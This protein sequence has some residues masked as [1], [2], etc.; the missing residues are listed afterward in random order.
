VA[1]L[2]CAIGCGESG[3]GTPGDSG[4]CGP[5]GGPGPSDGGCTGASCPTD[6]GPGTDGG[7]AAAPLTATPD[8]V[9]IGTTTGSSKSGQVTLQNTSAATVS[10]QSLPL[11]GD[12]A[13]AFQVSGGGTLPADLAPGASTTL[14]V[15]FNGTAGVSKAMLSA[16]TPAG[17][18][19]VPLGGMGLA[20]GTEP[21]L[22]WIF[23]VHNIPV[24]A[25]N[26]D[27]SKRDFPPVPIAG[28]ETGIQSF[29]KA[30][31]GPVTLQ[32][33][34]SF[35]PTFEPVSINGWYTSGNASARNNLFTI[36]QAEA[37]ALDP[38]PES[39]T[40]SFD[41]GTTAFGFWN[42]WPFWEQQGKYVIYQ[43]DTLNTWDTGNGGVQHHMRVYPYRNPDGTQDPH[44]YILTTEEAPISAGPDY[45]DIV[46]V[47]RN[48]VPASGGGGALLIQNQDG[49]PANDRMI[50]SIITTIASCWG[51]LTVK[52]TGALTVRNLS[53]SN[54]NVTAVDVTDDFTVTPST[55]LPA[56]LAPG[57]SLDL[58]VKFVATT[59]RVH[60]GTLT[61]HS[62]DS[63]APTRTV[64]L[65]GFRQ[66]IPQNSAFPGT[67]TEPDL[68]EVVNGLYGYSTVVG[69]KQQ[70]FDAGGFLNAVGD[71]VLSSYWVKAEPS[72][73]VTVR[74]MGAWHSGWDCADATAV[75]YGS[76]AYWFPKGRTGNADDR[77]ILGGAKEDIQRALPRRYE[78]NHVDAAS[79]SFDPGSTVFGWHIE[80]E[81]SDESMAQQEPWCTA[82]QVCGHRIRFWPVKDA[83]GATVQNTWLIAVDMHRRNPFFANYDFNDETYL[84]RNMM[85]APP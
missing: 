65:A 5:D 66:D 70:L 68:D 28:D 38:T 23:D 45:N 47:I 73:P 51:P 85:P 62:D 27:P 41:P 2:V 9:V 64:T 35:G 81:F 44:A 82:G 63:A 6:G 40:L 7:P 3:G 52:D 36:P 71:E 53:G 32:L 39:G 14:T 4:C 49:E 33:L 37:F 58:T 74:L 54:V 1:V 43:E 21:S 13:G 78:N 25:G 69:T 79:G 75:S 15:T 12:G 31:D 19:V 55:A 8:R 50:F 30:G 16:V 42:E 17:T 84:V 80:D 46:Y 26:P 18:T 61:V 60:S 83:S 67:S 57:A 76:F 77:Y 48:V 10:L 56:A 24:N 34:G 29:V 72:Q 59:G 11:S 22:Q 20:A